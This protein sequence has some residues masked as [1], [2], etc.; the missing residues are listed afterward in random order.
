MVGNFTNLYQ[1]AFWRDAAAD[2]TGIF[3]LLPV[4]VI[5]LIAVPVSFVNY[6]CPISRGSTGTA[7]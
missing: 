7:A 4:L 2:Q 1:M 6:L 5:E 3:K